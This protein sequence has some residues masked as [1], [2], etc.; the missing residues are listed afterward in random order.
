MFAKWWKFTT[1]KQLVTS[2]IFS[3]KISYIYIT[4]L[5]VTSKFS[6]KFDVEIIYGFKVGVINFF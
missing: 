5:K 4:I 2:L 6:N 3:F 1:K